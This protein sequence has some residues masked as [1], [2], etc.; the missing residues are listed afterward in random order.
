MRIFKVTAVL[1]FI[2][3]LLGSCSP[4][5]R[6]EITT[7]EIEAHLRFLSDD[8]LE[9][10]A[11]GSRGEALAALYQETQFKL[12]GVEPFF[13]EGYGQ[14]FTLKG[15][16]PDQQVTLEIL[17]GRTKAACPYRVR[18]RLGLEGY[19]SN[20]PLG[21]GNHPLVGRTEISSSVSS[22]QLL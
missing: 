22:D 20:L 15:S 21:A 8:L 10:R 2:M 18:T 13:E 19:G 16:L 5:N 12:S 17:S 3:I 11:T 6:S 7:G 14:P 1:V 9:G 4:G